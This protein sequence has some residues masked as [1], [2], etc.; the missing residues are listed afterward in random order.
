MFLAV[1]PKHTGVRHPP[2]L[3]H[4]LCPGHSTCP[5]AE[6]Y[7]EP[8]SHPFQT[9]PTQII[10]CALGD[11]PPQS[12]G[13]EAH[14]I[15]MCVWRCGGVWVYVPVSILSQA[16]LSQAILAQTILPQAFSDQVALVFFGI[17]PNTTQ[18]CFFGKL[19]NINKFEIWV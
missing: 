15:Y 3:V 13:I 6:G 1:A 16:M 4:L 19:Q 9:L 2:P 8:T 14:S 10:K 18:S 11:I 7:K 12:Q 5:D 17:Q